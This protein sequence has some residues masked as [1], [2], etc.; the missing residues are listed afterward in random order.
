M[1]RDVFHISGF[2]VMDAPGQEIVQI[3][4]N[5]AAPLAPPLVGSL[6]HLLAPAQVAIQ[7]GTMELWRADR[8]QA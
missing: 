1:I 7:V 5:Q 6:H 3:V 8:R 2:L 4:L